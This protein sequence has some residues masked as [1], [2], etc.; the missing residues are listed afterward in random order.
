MSTC[1]CYFY[2]TKNI[3]FTCCSYLFIYCFRTCSVACMI[4]MFTSDYDMH[5]CMYSMNVISFDMCIPSQVIVALS[6]L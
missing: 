3:L 4:Q 1:T 5:V 2:L 6:A